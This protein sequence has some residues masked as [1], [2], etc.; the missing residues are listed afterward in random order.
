MEQP[1]RIGKIAPWLSCSV[2]CSMPR[3]N[4]NDKESVSLSRR[5]TARNGSIAGQEARS[6]T[7]M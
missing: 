2:C 4:R 7:E 3:I 5:K 6:T 1:H